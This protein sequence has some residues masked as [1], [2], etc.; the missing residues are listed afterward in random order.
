[1]ER[2]VSG[3]KKMWNVSGCLETGG[4]EE[5]EVTGERD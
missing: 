2:Q 1:M 5:L 3:E 4:V